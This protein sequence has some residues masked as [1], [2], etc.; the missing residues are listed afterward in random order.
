[1]TLQTGFILRL[2]LKAALIGLIVAYA[3]RHGISL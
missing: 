1:M 2:L 3:A